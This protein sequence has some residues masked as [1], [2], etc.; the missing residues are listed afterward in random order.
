MKSGKQRRIALDAKKTARAAKSAAQRAASARAT[1]ERD[2]A[3]GVPVNLDLLGP[4]RSYSELDF[5]TRGYYVDRP[6]ECV[7]CGAS[8][9]WTAAQQKWW[10]EVAKGSLYATAVRCRAC[11]RKHSERHEG[12]GDPNPIKH[13]GSLMKCVRAG[14]E[15]CLVKAGFEFDGQ[16]KG[17]DSR[18]AWL[19]YAR[20]GSILR[21]RF[22]PR[23]ARL[24]AETMDDR[25]EC[26]TVA[27]AELSRLRSASALP[28]RVD[29]FILA[30][31]EFVRTLPLRKETQGDN[32]A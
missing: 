11:R 7:D 14:I 16:Q 2:A 1:R 4:H 17:T 12:Q 24:I 9:V 18:A 8:E 13:L 25:T 29:D 3:R 20:S 31:R 6:F 26:R 28:Q 30:V 15:P 5:V 21:C 10:Y 32:G 22:E 23:D 27:T 19:D